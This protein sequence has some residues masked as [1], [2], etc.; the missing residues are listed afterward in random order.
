MLL[1]AGDVGGTKTSLAV[2][3]PEAGL[4]APLAEATFPSKRYAGLVDLIRDFLKHTQ[5][6]IDNAVF[7]VAGPVVDGVVEATNLP[8]IINRETLRESLGL[9]DVQ[10]LNDLE[11]I[12]NG[13]P[14]LEP[15]DVHTIHPGHVVPHAPI[16]V[17]APGTGLGEAFLT[18]ADGRYQAHPSEG[19]HVSFGPRNELELEL[20]RF[21]MERIGHVSYERVCSGIGIPNI[22]RFLKETGRASEPEQL[23]QALADAPD[24]T[25][26]IMDTAMTSPGTCEICD[27]T[28]EMFVA[29]LGSEA[30]NLALKVLARGGVYLGGGIPPRILPALTD[31]R[32]WKAFVDKGRLSDVLEEMPVHVILNPK[33]ALLGAASYGL[34]HMAG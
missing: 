8:W 7:G 25:P 33:L 20:L 13:I 3:T 32:F 22:Y 30:G 16:A 21:L 6:P 19:G 4:R 9:K 12:G 24:P 10:L 23:T 26:I 31:G 14:I 11:A 2:I 34:V 17:I 27:L 15:A 5:L 29:I 1:L 28:L 18:W